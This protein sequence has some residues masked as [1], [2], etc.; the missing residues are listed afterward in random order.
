M[1][2]ANTF[3]SRTVVASSVPVI[4]IGWSSGCLAI[5]SW[6]VV[7]LLMWGTPL[8]SNPLFLSQDWVSRWKQFLFLKAVFPY[9]C[10]FSPDSLGLGLGL[11]PF[12]SWGNTAC[13]HFGDKCW[14][15]LVCHV[16]CLSS[17]QKLLSCCSS[18]A[19]D[20]ITQRPL[21][22]PCCLDPDI[23]KWKHRKSG[24]GTIKSGS[25]WRMVEYLGAGVFSSPISNPHLCRD[26]FVPVCGISP[27]PG[28]KACRQITYS[29]LQRALQWPF[30]S[31]SIPS[32]WHSEL[33]RRTCWIVAKCE[34]KINWSWRHVLEVRKIFL[35]SDKIRVITPPLFA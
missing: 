28:P 3:T 19:T 18:S 31:T 30:S 8:C 21:L 11:T 20:T 13:N 15:Y 12:L 6:H 33:R 27:C 1:E 9:P 22:L 25:V 4:R 16:F 24:P 2:G 10:F 14:F 34:L 7:F 5:D 29:P 35:A 32:L 23:T 26:S 17:G